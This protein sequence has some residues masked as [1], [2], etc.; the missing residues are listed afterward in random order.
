MMNETSG[1][2]GGQVQILHHKRSEITKSGEAN[3]SQKTNWTAII[4][5]SLGCVVILVVAI[6]FLIKIF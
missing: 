1:N 2:E 5:M 6:Y 4:V 3:G